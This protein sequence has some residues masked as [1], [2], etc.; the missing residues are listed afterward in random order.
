MMEMDQVGVGDGWS[1]SSMDME[2][3]GHKAEWRWSRIELS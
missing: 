2:Q 3:D 1:W